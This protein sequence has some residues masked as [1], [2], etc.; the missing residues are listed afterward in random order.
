[1][2]KNATGMFLIVFLAFQG[3]YG[4]PKGR[5]SNIPFSRSL[6]EDISNENF[7][8]TIENFDYPNATLLELAEAIGKLTG[9]NFII[10]PGLAGKK[11]KIIAPSKITVAEA[12]K[13]FLS[14]L[15]ANG[16][17][18]VKKDAFWKI[19]S[20][21][22]ALKDNIEIY[23][24]DY[25]PNTDQLITRIIKLKNINA[26]K[27]SDST[28]YLLSQENAISH[29]EETNS[30]II[31]DYGSVIEKIM[32]LVEKMDLPGSKEQVKVIPIQHADAGDLSSILNQL[33]FKSR[34]SRTSFSRGVRG[35]RGSTLPPP[36]SSQGK[37]LE[38]NLKISIIIP[39]ERTNS[40]IVSANER[41]FAKVKELVKKLDTYVDPARNG[42]I[43]VY[44]VLYGTAGQ[45]YETLTGLGSKS[46][47]AKPAKTGGSKGRSFRQPYGSF[48]SGKSSQSPLFDNVTIMADSHTNS[49]IISA[50]NRYDF[51]RV[52]SVLKRID[53]PKDQVFVQAVI[54]EM[55]VDKGDHWEV[56]FATALTSWLTNHSWFKA[57]FPPTTD[58]KAS[59]V[60]IAGFLNQSFDIQSLTKGIK[61]GPGLILGAP[62]NSL[63]N[64]FNL[65][66]DKANASSI[67][68]EQL[69]TIADD[70]LRADVLKST[71]RS[72]NRLTNLT[73][74]SMFPL[75]QI[76]KK[77][78]N[79]N[80]LS[81]PQITALDNIKAFIEVGEN[82]P[83][84]LTS[85]TN[86][87][88]V[89]VQNSLERKDVTIRLEI[90]PS[91]NSDS[92][93]V[94]MEITQKF[95]DFSARQSTASELKDRGVHILKR[96]IETTLVL[97]DGEIAVLGGLMVEKETKNENKIPILGDIPIL[98][99]LFKGSILEKQKNNLL[100]FIKPT[101]IEGKNQKA[102]TQKLLGK[103]LEERIHFVKKYMKGRDPHGHFLKSLRESTPTESPSPSSL[104]GESPADDVLIPP[105]PQ[106]T[107]EGEGKILKFNEENLPDNNP[108]EKK[109]LNEEDT[110]VEIY[111]EDQTKEED[112]EEEEDYGEEDEWE[113]EEDDEEELEEED[114]EEEEEE[115]LI[116]KKP[117]LKENNS[118]A[119]EETTPLKTQPS[120]VSEE[121]KKEAARVLKDTLSEESPDNSSSFKESFPSAEKG[122]LEEEPSDEETSF[123]ILPF[124]KD[125]SK[126]KA[127]KKKGKPAS[128]DKNIKRK[129]EGGP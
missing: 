72:S 124:P 73:H 49:L 65:D 11:I 127:L 54:V 25:F 122:P 75:L 62:L 34:K 78:G 37:S 29:H 105:Y 116:L 66:P 58:G 79:F 50:R 112:Y 55:A 5:Q 17:T 36:L 23:S 118:S 81:T 38:G 103:K 125:N 1:M 21:K 108:E 82:A 115:E 121:N 64:Q 59:L 13:A 74:L 40:L 6:P 14:A 22:S 111:K 70:K 33:I 107:L 19:T 69:N 41:G 39:D 99:W 93:T 60:P 96:E 68:R 63:M 89:A 119:I 83:V 20:T 48:S 4:S 90:T 28:K 117:P 15:A 94:Q 110:E 123:E 32:K 106:E 128:T 43:Y 129:T 109:E 67:T 46:G 71:G 120:V 88:S 80:I 92:G 77:A 53:V 26:K 30:I 91:I 87:G 18:L 12:Y 42:G 7:P 98:G 16:Y 76:L 51:E 35:K 114:Y 104:P 2:M 86:T 61:F 47:A 113:E 85:T 27:F 101:I 10:D 8:D 126:N 97:N 24:G 52:K 9:L 95:N 84:G 3:V 56:N 45:I 102:D 44:N 100:V 57:I 31:S